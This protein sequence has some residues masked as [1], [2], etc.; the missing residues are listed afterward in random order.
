[1]NKI[2][3]R[4]DR[5]SINICIKYLFFVFVFGVI[6]I[7]CS[8]NYSLFGTY[9]QKDGVGKNQ[10]SITI[11]EDGTCIFKFE[12]SDGFE[13]VIKNYEVNGNILV[14]HSEDTSD[15]IFII[16]KNKLIRK[17]GLEDAPYYITFK[18]QRQ[19]E[20]LFT[21]GYIDLLYDSPK[22][23]WGSS[24][25]EVKSKYPNI[26]ESYFGGYD[27]NEN[28]LNG[29]IESRIFHFYNNKLY[30]VNI[31]YGFYKKD[32]VDILKKEL[33]KKYGDFLIKYDEYWYVINKKNNQVVFSI[34]YMGNYLVNCIYI[35]QQIKNESDSYSFL[36]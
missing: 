31:S 22:V 10:S 5:N 8:M 34:T 25:E 3:K 16:K 9:L 1:M 32:E 17:G 18:K 36:K 6:F 12:F 2:I 35:N 7:S 13:S 14:V 28:N 27:D 24:I 33:Q 26:E 20:E 21:D 29:R 19:K 30:M 11:N 15:S 23:L 4:S